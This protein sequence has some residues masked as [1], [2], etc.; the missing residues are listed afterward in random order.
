MRQRRV[1]NRILQLQRGDGSYTE[2]Q[3]EIDDI[4]AQ[5]F[6]TTFE[7]TAILSYDQI[8]AEIGTLPLPQLSPH[9]LST[10]DRPITIEEIEDTVF[11]LGSHKAP[12]PVFL[13]FS[14][15]STKALS[16]LTSL[17]LS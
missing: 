6:K 7:D 15:K 9:Q 16:N 4:L 13:P 1:G 8:L 11:Q 17:T 10:L 5:H 12:G 3:G 2:D 14:I